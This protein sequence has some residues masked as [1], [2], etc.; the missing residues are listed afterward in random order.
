[1][2]SPCFYCNKRWISPA[3]TVYCGVNDD[4]TE[5]DAEYAKEVELDCKRAKA[6]KA[7][8]DAKTERFVWGDNCNWKDNP[9]NGV[10]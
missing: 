4:R 3:G 8:I 9:D 2:F 10:I 7:E 1:M 6:K 5:T